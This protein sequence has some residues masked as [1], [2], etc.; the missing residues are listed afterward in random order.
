MSDRKGSARGWLLGGAALVAVCP[1]A[2][3]VWARVATDGSTASKGAIPVPLTGSNYVIG[4]EYGT[5]SKS[6]D[7]LFDS[8]SQFS[9]AKGQTDTFTGPSNLS[10]IITRVTGGDAS[11]ID[12]TIATKTG[13]HPG[14]YLINPYGV[15]F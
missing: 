1:A 14:F 11:T 7:N 3:P 8:F 13:G 12:G 9:L 2:A 10:N 5:L 4:P 6:G 15:I